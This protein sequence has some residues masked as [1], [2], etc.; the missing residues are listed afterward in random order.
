MIRTLEGSD[1]R[2]QKT[3][4]SRDFYGNRQKMI[5][6]IIGEKKHTKNEIVDSRG[7]SEIEELFENFDEGKN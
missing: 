4:V 1:V 5:T 3:I 2:R 6:R 7:F